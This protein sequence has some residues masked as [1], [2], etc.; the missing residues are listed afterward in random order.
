LKKEKQDK[1]VIFAGRYNDSEILSGPEKVANRIFHEYSKNNKTIFIQYFFDGRKYSIFKKLFGK[2]IKSIDA[3]SLILTLGLFRIFLELIKIRPHI[4]HLITFERYC[5]TLYLFKIFTKTRIIYNEHGIVTYENYELK[6]LPFFYRIKDKFCEKLFLKYSN[7]II[8]PSFQSVEIAKKY[9]RLK[10]DLIRVLP[11]GCDTEFA[12]IKRC[13][14]DPINI[15]IES[16][17]IS[18]EQTDE[19]LKNTFDKIKTN[20]NLFVIGNSGKLDFNNN[21]YINLIYIDKMNKKTFQDFLGKMCL[22]LSVNKYDTFS[23]STLEAMCTGAIP[24]VTEETGISAYIRN[25]VNGFTVPFGDSDR[26]SEIINTISTSKRLSQ[27]ISKRAREIINELSWEN[28]YKQY[29]DL[30]NSME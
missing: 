25:G 24:I 4:I 18:L 20:T 7:I 28:V 10:S 27:D 30:Y 5:V 1:K 8:F 2:E 11:N 12:G 21:E 13:N 9:F 3:N 15:A 17:K 6:N 14:G 29:L 26:L 19:F 16:D 23:I 22:F